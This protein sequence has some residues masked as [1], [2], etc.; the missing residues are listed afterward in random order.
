M[1]RGA[2]EKGSVIHKSHL[3]VINLSV[4][5]GNILAPPFFSISYVLL[6]A[7]PIYRKE[8]P[9]SYCYKILTFYVFIVIFSNLSSRVNNQSEKEK[10]IS[11]I[12]LIKKNK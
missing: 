6:S 11:T 4:P 3:H 1:A 8:S 7:N 12:N 10:N 2:N 9:I 5:Q